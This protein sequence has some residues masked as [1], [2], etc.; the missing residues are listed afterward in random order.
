[1]ALEAPR[2]LDKDRLMDLVRVREA[3]Y[4]IA[5]PSLR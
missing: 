1:V 2:P 4:R 3:R 5:L